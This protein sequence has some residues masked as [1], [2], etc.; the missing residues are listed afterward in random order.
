AQIGQSGALAKTPGD[1]AD[2]RRDTPASACRLALYAL[3]RLK[4]YP[5]VAAAVLDP[6]GQPRVRWWPAA[7]ALQRLEDKRAL[8]ALLALAKDANPYARA[9]AVKGLG[10]LKDR[11]AL[12]V[13]MPLLTSGQRS[14]LIQTI[15][16]PGKIGHASA[17]DPL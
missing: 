10:A 17:V 1:D 11:S 5:Q 16:A 7:F 13:L 12:P 4:A 6:N 2:R 8:P 9:F 3:V 14:V 15:R